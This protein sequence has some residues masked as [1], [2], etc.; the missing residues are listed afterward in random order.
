MSPTPSDL[1]DQARVFAADISDLLNRT[2]ADGIRVSAVLDP[3]GTCIVG[4]NVT[5]TSF[6]PDL[7]PVRVNKAARCHLRVGY[8]LVLDPEGVHLTV[9]KSDVSL[10]LDREGTKMILHYDYDREPA[11]DYPQ[12]HFQVAGDAPNLR[13]LAR[14]GERGDSRELHDFHFPVGGRRF[15]PTLEDVVEFLIVEQL[16]EARAG[17]QD[18]IEEHRTT[19]YQ[20]QLLAA[21]RRDPDLV[22]SY[23]AELDN[24]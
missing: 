7:I 20:R 3:H 17:W 24:D 18:A 15:R 23:L 1:P 6:L 8:V 11:N 16:A 4:R 13:A 5:K 10:Y 12:A 2:V 19:W 9:A 22:R 14:A 21:V